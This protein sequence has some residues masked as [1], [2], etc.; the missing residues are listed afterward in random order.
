MPSAAD[1]SSI[2][3]FVTCVGDLV[4]PEVPAAAVRVLRALGCA[5]DV[6]EGQ[7]CCGQPA[8][9]SGFSGP[10]A[11]VA[12]TSLDALTA[13]V[14]AGAEAVV[15]PAGSC[16]AMVKL[17]WPELFA[18]EGDH[19]RAQAAAA[20]APV[21]HEFT[22]FLAHR[23]PLPAA[24]VGERAAATPVVLHRSCHLLR[25]LRV[26]DQPVDAL[27]RSPACSRVEWSTD[28]TCCGFGG[29]F[30]VKLPETS[31]AMA[32]H[33]LDTV[34]DGVDLIVGADSTCLLHL[35]A[36]AD[37]RGLPVTT[38]HVAEVLADALG[39]TAEGSRG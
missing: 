24:P 31:V 26:V 22:E 37:A 2:A 16:A 32:D 7:T 11:K 21:V 27:E 13:A 30:S 4:Q 17:T 29:T 5:V 35:Q 33:K 1:A 36:R 8:W 28:D 15:V 23:A 38:R 12:A 14:A 25:E 10:A 34:P 6:P 3:L 18:L 39:P 19:R 9:N 20:L